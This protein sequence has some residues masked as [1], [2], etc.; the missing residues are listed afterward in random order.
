MS[1]S[2]SNF[3]S[4]KFETFCKRLNIEQVFLSLYH[5]QSNGQVEACIKL[6]KH[7]LKKCF[8]TKGDVHIALLQI[9][10]TPLGPGFPSPATILF[11]CPIRG[12]MPKINNEEHY[13]AILNR[14]TKDDKNQGNPRN[15]VFIL[16]G[17]TIA[18]KCE[19]GGL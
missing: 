5:H 9:Q 19:D 3:I 17:P 15:Y 7:T 16:T 4:D 13:E 18:V 1:D 12:I 2:G 8:D 11:N 6:V 14:Q 10:M